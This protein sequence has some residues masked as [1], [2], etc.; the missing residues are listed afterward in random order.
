MLAG[1][2]YFMIKSWNHDN[3]LQAMK[4]DVW[5]TQ[6]KN[7]KLLTEAFRTSR[8]VILLFSVNKSMAFQGYVHLPPFPLTHPVHTET[9]STGANDLP[10][11]PLNPQAFLLREAE[12]GHVLCLLT[13]LAGYYTRTL[14][15]GRASEEHVQS[16]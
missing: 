5:A 7:E 1:V 14:S 6:E 11:P 4:D 2:R 13:P 12:L 8:H 3:V 10:T 15:Y 9:H 16:G